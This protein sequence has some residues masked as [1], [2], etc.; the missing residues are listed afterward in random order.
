[1]IIRGS[2]EPVLVVISVLVAI[3]SSY[4]ALH[5]AGR[6]RVSRGRVRQLWLAAA[7][8]A[9]GGGIWS[10]HFV[11]MLAFILPVPVSY[12][13]DLT[14]SSLLVAVIV[15]GAAFALVSTHVPTRS[16]IG[17]AGLLMGA[18]ICS[19][20]YIGMAA[21]RMPVHVTYDPGTVALSFLIATGTSVAAL[22]LA[23]RVERLMERIGAAIVMGAAV[24]G[25]HY[26]GMAAM[27][28]STD[29]VSGGLARASD[30]PQLY[31]AIGIAALT[32]IMLV[33]AVASSAVDRRIA[34]IVAREAESLRDS[35]ERH[36]RLYAVLRRETAERE[37]ADRFRLVVEAAPNAMLIVDARGVVTLVNAQAERLFGYTREELLGQPIEILVPARFRSQHPG[38]RQG[39]FARPSVRPMG[40]G[41]DLYGLRKDGSEVPIEIGLNPI[42]AAGATFVLASIIDITERKRAEVALRDLTDEL[43]HRVREEVAAREA[44][45]AQ[46]A[47]AQ[48]VQALGQLAGGIA[49]D[50]NNILQAVTGAMSLIEQRA[51]DAE[52]TRRLALMA[53]DAANRGASI[54][55]RLL[56]FAR[57]SELRAEPINTMELL[58][59]MGEILTHTLG[60]SITVR[61]LA[62]RDLPWLLA[63]RGQ[64]E[65][66]LVNLAANARDAMPNGGTLTIAATPDPIRT[67]A[68]HP[69]CLSVGQYVRITIA[70]TGLGMDAAT[71][72]RVTEPFFT[73]KPPGKGT[74]LGLAMVRGFAEQ[75]GGGLSIESEPGKGTVIA[76]WLRTAGTQVIREERE[77]AYVPSGP[78]GPAD[79]FRILLVDDDDLV[80]ETLA[81]E[82]EALGCATL[83]A[84]NGTE[85]LALLESGESLDAL[86][87][88][89]LMPGMNGIE[90]IQKARQIHPGLRCFLLT[91]YAG[92]ARTSIT[93]SSEFTLVLK[94]VG[95][96]ELL[97]RILGCGELIAEGER[98]A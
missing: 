73:T 43:E 65:T 23:F 76:L 55:R 41:R 98:G 50:F 33:L 96:R 21:M 1:M 74:G 83:V 53:F 49:H 31:V 89:L 13:L 79:V 67:D 60:S 19:M 87:S 85:A 9:M 72:A 61:T 57:R 69:A 42:E 40:A 48:K 70:D 81:A 15:T 86:V 11:A 38:M 27:T 32:L 26:T 29:D 62:G 63:D 17:A 7:A 84:C 75:S 46:L 95:A 92:D 12:E 16:R 58:T 30:L 80:R 2:F 82:L 91:G 77:T 28:C 24:A 36:R 64:L 44:T 8:V 45:Q 47:Q 52:A 25:M 3:A 88:D 90:T 34:T 56:S 35:E 59:S 20:H 5:L 37:H 97:A 22:W 93:S 94:P 18:G 66:A 71:L 6:I 78:N 4:T 10:M 68:V 51:G 39:F 14:A 54:T